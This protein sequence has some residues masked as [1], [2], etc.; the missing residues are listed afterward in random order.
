MLFRSWDVFGL[1]DDMVCELSC[2]PNPTSGPIHVRLS[3]EQGSGIP[4]QIFDMTGRCIYS[5]NRYF[6]KGQ[7]VF[8][9]HANYPQGLYLLRIGDQTKRIAIE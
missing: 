4:I 8:T 6:H 7:T 2:Y 1:S 5:E 9:I 3:V